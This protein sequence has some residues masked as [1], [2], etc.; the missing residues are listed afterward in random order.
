MTN[1]GWTSFLISGL[2]FGLGG[3][4]GGN[5][6][7]VEGQLKDSDGNPITG[8]RITAT[9]E[10]P[11]KGYEQLEAV[12]KSDGTFR[13]T[14]LFPSS[15]YVLKPWVDDRSAETT[16]RIR[17]APQGA[18]AILPEPVLIVPKFCMPGRP[19]K[20]PDSAYIEHGDGTVTDVRT[21]LMWKQCAEGLSGATCATGSAQGFTWANALS[22][23]EGSTFG[24]HADWRL[25]S[26]DELH[27]LV[28]TCGAVINNHLFPNTP[29]RPFWSSSP[30]PDSSNSAWMV[31]FVH[32][33][34]MTHYVSN[35]FAVRLVRGGK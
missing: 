25:P 26:R 34:P 31:S 2:V 11:L 3:C 14:G 12:S 22:Y 33:N 7:A 21:G 13:I 18:T 27:G 8:M 16:I 9:Q 32:G 29:R 23:A 35:N 24:N 20:N 28:E 30:D 5:Q 1:R 4:G 15:A 17:S 10:Q 19:A 6:S